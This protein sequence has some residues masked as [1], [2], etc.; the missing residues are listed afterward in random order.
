MA[1]SKNFDVIVL[2]AGAAGMMCAIEAG[3]R[4]KSVAIID[5]AKAP[6]EKIRISGGGHCNFT[7]VHC[8]PK[9]FLSENPAFA[10]SALKAY[11]PQQFIDWVRKTG[12]QF[13]EKTLG[14]MFCDGYAVDII[15]MLTRAMREVNVA[16][17]LNTK[18]EHVTHNENG[19]C[20]ETT[21]G[22]FDAARLVVATGGKSIPKMGAT[23]LGYDLARQF[24]HRVTDLRPAL[25]PFTWPAHMFETWSEL[26]GV[27]LPVRAACGTGRFDEALLMTHRGL[28][29][30]AMLQIS[31]YWREG[32]TVEIDLAPGHD[33]AGFLKAA[34]ASHGKSAPANVLAE[35]FPKRLA[36]K[37]VDAFA[38]DVLRLADMGN[39]ALEG[40]AGHIKKFV[41]S[42]GGTE[43][44]R[45]AEVT[46]GGVATGGLN[47]KTMESK[48]VSGLYFIGEVVDMTGH[49]GG[50]NFQWAWASGAAAGRN[51]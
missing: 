44:Y 1:H 22:V 3:R 20:V 30:P 33:M 23:G 47:Q 39:A 31:S 14:Q 40:L 46:L 49:L 51:V 17:M 27:A 24:G 38:T 34:R 43:G 18:I 4:G 16:L 32:Q 19:F 11:P 7:N 9:N 26:S 50:H 41:F 12:I 25:V 15:T 21:E 48:T 35:L 10:I 45:T 6:G 8:G 5:H 29:G 42:P 36:Q 13:H 37:L 28:S 2:G